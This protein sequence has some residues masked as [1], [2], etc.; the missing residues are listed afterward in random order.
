MI[1]FIF[2]I[3]RWIGEPVR[4]LVLPTT[5]FI[6]NKKGFPVLGKGH[7]MLVKRFCSL[8]V[9]FIITGAN[10]YRNISFYYHYLDYIWKVSI[11]YSQ[12]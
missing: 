9:Q 5:L 3:T 4:C 1:R 10:R 8:N 11:Y 7:Q 12:S 2:Q 6:S